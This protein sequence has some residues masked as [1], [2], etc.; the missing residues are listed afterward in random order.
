MTTF[1]AWVGVDSRA[2]ASI[3]FA[4]D[5][6]ISWDSSGSNHWDAGQKTFSSS[7]SP[8]IFAYVNDV[9]FPSMVLGQV[10]TAIDNGVLFGN[11]DTCDMRFDKIVERIKKAHSIY[12]SALR[13]SFRI[14]HGA[15]QGEGLTS[16]FSLNVVGWQ[17]ETSKWSIDRLTIPDKSSAITIDGSGKEVFSKWSTRWNSSSQGGTSRAVFSSFCNAVN[18]RED[19][20][21]RGA[22]QVVSLYRAGPGKTIG[23]IDEG[24]KFVSGMEIQSVDVAQN[25]KFEWRNKY[26]ER[27][28]S[29]GNLVDGAQKHHV[30]K[31]LNL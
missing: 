23:F 7:F 8:D 15:R 25:A 9:M 13:H 6:R 14:F 20:L 1:I 19:K 28:D 18:S 16:K 30:P 29:T 17:K 4:T 3:N 22:P 5:S 26:F 11:D 2:L 24:S 21:T 12:P 10:V 31:G 27:C